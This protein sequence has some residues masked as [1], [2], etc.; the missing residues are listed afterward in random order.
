MQSQFQ[1]LPILWSV[2]LM[3]KVRVWGGFG[4]KKSNSGRQFYIQDR[5]FDSEG[6]CPALT[7]YKADYWIVI[8]DVQSS[9]EGD[10]ED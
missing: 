5:I 10:N 7:E 6:L 9:V 2:C 8:K 4:E 3:P 1:S